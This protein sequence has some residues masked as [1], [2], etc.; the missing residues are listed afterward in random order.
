MLLDFR[1]AF[2]R[3]LKTPAFTFIAALTLALGLSANITVFSMVNEFMLRPLQVLRPAELVFVMQKNAKFQIP[4][5]YSFP[6]FLD[7]RTSL[8]GEPAGGGDS[9]R[10]FADLIAE[11]MFPVHLSEAGQTPERAWVHAVSANYFE[12]LGAHA[13]R[14]QLFAAN[15]TTGTSSEPVVVLSH[16]FWTTHFHGNPEVIGQTVA[17]NGAPFTVIGVAPEGFVGTQA[18]VG[19][20]MFVPAGMWD[21]LQPGQKG[22]LEHRGNSAFLL[23]GRLRP[24]VSLEQSRAAV[25]AV[26]TRLI[27]DHPD[28]HAPATARV[29]PE[30]MSRPS[31]HVSDVTPLALAALM[32]LA[33]LVLGVAAANIANLLYARAADAERSLA[34]RS[35]LGATRWRLVR[36][37][38]AESVLLALASAVLGWFASEGFGQ[39]LSRIALSADNPPPVQPPQSWQ[40]FAFTVVAALATGLATGLFPALRATRRDVLP[41][42][43]EATRSVSGGR[44]PLRSFLVCS[45]ITLSCVV[46]VCAGL[47]ARSL[48]KLGSVDLGFRAENVLLATL[49]LELQRYD[50]ARAHQFQKNLLD[51]VRALP[52]VENASLTRAA[53]FDRSVGLRG[54]IGAEGQPPP[55]RDE[56]YLI[57]CVSASPEY[58]ATLGLPLRSGRDFTEHDTASSTLVTIIDETTAAHF[59]PGENP[60]GKRLVFGDQRQFE[61]VG[62]VGRASYLMMGDQG[63]PFIL[64]PLE[65][66]SSINVTLAIRTAADPRQL[67]RPLMELVHRLDRDL[68]VQNVRTLEQQIA[69]SPLGLMPLRL[70]AMIASAQGGLVLLLAIMGLYGLVSF[71]VA[72]RTREIGIRIALGATR[73]DILKLITRPSL[74]L[75]GVGL[76]LGLGLAFLV[77]RP[78]SGLLYGASPNDPLVFVGVS[79]LIAAV[80][81]L[82]A[83][84]PARR[85]TRVDPLTALHAE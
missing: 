47:A 73:R 17:I 37:L 18:M 11:A 53:P 12:L 62:V 75:T 48:H 79:V 10:P 52:G 57:A 40:P 43:N 46:L 61:V 21:V 29:V 9:A 24:G 6:D 81:I 14:G 19:A 45:Q 35:S 63:R 38:L 84:I 7:L 49:D 56:L 76:A 27:A 41:L 28:E 55:D 5:G 50:H 65:Q 58:R 66:E 25:D 67:A 59:W 85:A 39:M 51:E 30:Q 26:V 2:R 60:L 78:L 13:L 1:H 23:M 44:H 16:A 36:Y 71:A 34:I 20:Q 72:R 68:P 15:Q 83:W 33:L 4:Y 8:A 32:L 31:P 64:L 82:G 80:T 22:G 54:G 42:L 77:T 3:L 70:G 69:E 74:I